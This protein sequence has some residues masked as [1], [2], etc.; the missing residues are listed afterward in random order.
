[1]MPQLLATGLTTAILSALPIVAPAPA[2]AAEASCIRPVSNADALS[3]T[4]WYAGWLSPTNRGD[5]SISVYIKGHPSMTDKERAIIERGIR[6]WNNVL[7]QCLDGTVRFTTASSQQSADVLLRFVPRWGGTRWGGVAGCLPTRCL[8]T[9]RSEHVNHPRS[10]AWFL[11]VVLHELGHVLGLGH[12]TNLEESTDLMGYGWDD[13]TRAVL[14]QCDVD[15]L[16]SIWSWAI[17]DGEA[18]PATGTYD[19]SQD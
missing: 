8:V 15:A 12:T 6:I 18:V 13:D 2:S 19:C 14:S 17:R 9:V 4:Y 10:D 7:A 11:D 1:M 16:A 3:T 5:T